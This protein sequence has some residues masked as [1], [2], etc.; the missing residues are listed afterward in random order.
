V[1]S[2]CWTGWNVHGRCHIRTV[3]H[4]CVY[5]DDVSVWMCQGLH[6]YSVDTE[7]KEQKQTHQLFN[8]HKKHNKILIPESDNSHFWV[9][10][11][12][13]TIPT[14]DFSTLQSLKDTTKSQLYSIY[15]PWIRNIMKAIIKKMQ[16]H[17]LYIMFTCNGESFI[18]D[19]IKYP[20]T[21]TL[22]FF[23]WCNSPC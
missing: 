17:Y 21:A 16:C 4:P 8:T 7:Q 15:T 2:D 9:W 10:L 6:M 23:A 19:Q 5:E 11:P 20:L 13:Q 14:V 18:T 3:S 12:N 1:P 22:I